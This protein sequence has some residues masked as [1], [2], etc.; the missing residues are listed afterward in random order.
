M[1]I[2][3]PPSVRHADA[4]YALLAAIA[5]VAVFGYIA[6][7]MLAAERGGLAGAIAEGK[8]AQLSAAADGALVLAATRLSVREAGV[9]PWRIDGRPYR[10][11]IGAVDVV[12]RIE[13][14]RGKIRLNDLDDDQVRLLFESAG[15]QGRA[16]DELTDAFLDWTDGDDAPRPFGAEATAYA[17]SGYRPRNGPFLTVGEIAL[18]R[19]MTPALYARIAPAATVFFG[20]GGS[21]SPQTAAPLAIAVMTGGGLQS[22]DVIDRQR[23]I[24]GQRTALEPES[25]L[26]LAARPLTIRVIASDN[27]GAR[28]ERVTII[29]FPR[30]VP[31]SWEI[32]YQE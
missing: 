24:A 14:E 30:G 5:A 22:K 23:A 3:K 19:G 21:F 32:R 2:S 6:F 10:A 18:I 13:D 20:A 11:T 28:L 1:P 26:D 9:A 8:R 17:Q 4:G 7:A 12:I 29:E 31:G 16:V 25:A 15:V 27:G